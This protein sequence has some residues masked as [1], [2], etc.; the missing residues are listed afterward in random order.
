MAENSDILAL[1]ESIPYPD[2]KDPTTARKIAEMIAAKAAQKQMASIQYQEGT[3]EMNETMFSPQRDQTDQA[4]EAEQTAPEVTTE[5]P[6]IGE[7]M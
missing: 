6:N 2:R 1:I 4:L 5:V 3:A 7:L